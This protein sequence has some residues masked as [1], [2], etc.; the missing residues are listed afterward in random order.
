MTN[1]KDRARDQ[2]SREA[3]QQ[4][5]SREGNRPWGRAAA[6]IEQPGTQ[7]QESK[8]RFVH[9]GTVWQTEA[10]N[11]KLILESQPNEWSDPHVRRA[12]VITKNQE[13]SNN[14]K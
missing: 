13:P 8:T 11:L 12:V 14:G 9:I 4:Q 7:R 1:Q 3:G 2:R 6:A 5:R 10:G